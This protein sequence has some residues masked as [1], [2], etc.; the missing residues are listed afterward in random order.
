MERT[1]K[2][3]FTKA[4]FRSCSQIWLAYLYGLW[5]NSFIEFLNHPDTDISV[6]NIHKY[7]L[8]CRLW[9]STINRIDVKLQQVMQTGN[10]LYCSKIKIKF[11]VNITCLLHSSKSNSNHHRSLT[12]TSN[13]RSNTIKET[14]SFSE[15]ISR[16]T[17]H[18]VVFYSS[19]SL[20]IKRNSPGF[21][22]L[23][24]LVVKCRHFSTGN[25]GSS[26]TLIV[27]KYPIPVSAAPKHDTWDQSVYITIRRIYIVIY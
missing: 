9:R 1:A 22:S 10:Q 6:K 23:L 13:N 2:N 26:Q 16:Y 19:A 8:T 5:R 21:L 27:Q 11:W 20:H 18:C 3:L 25:S 17:I 14:T 12:V 15:L 24:D 4:S 7:S